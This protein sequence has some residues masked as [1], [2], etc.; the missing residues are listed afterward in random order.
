MIRLTNSYIPKVLDLIIVICGDLSGLNLFWELTLRCP[1][2]LF[3]SIRIVGVEYQM[4]IEMQ[5][6]QTL[7][8]FHLANE[9][10]IERN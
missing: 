9:E 1:Q 4:V 7:T 6:S 10:L 2:G 5:K 8:L 3:A